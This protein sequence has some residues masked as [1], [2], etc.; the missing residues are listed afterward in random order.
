MKKQSRDV[1]TVGFALFAMF[2]GAGNIIFPPFIGTLGGTEWWKACLGF[3]LTGTGLPLLGVYAVAEAGGSS[4]DLFRP[5]SRHFGRVLITV[6]LIFIGPLFAIPRT[7]ATTYELSFYPLLNAAGM[8]DQ[9]TLLW[10][11][12]GSLLF[13]AICA[14][15]VYKPSDVVDRIGNILTPILILFLLI[16]IVMSLVAPIG[17]P[18]PRNFDHSLFRFGFSNGYQTMDALASVV[19]AG[20]IISTIRAKGYRGRRVTSMAKSAG[21]IAASGTAIVYLGFT[22]IGASGSDRLAPYIESGRTTLI[23]HAVYLLTGTFGNVLLGLI[24]LFACLTTAIGIITT[25]SDYFYDLFHRRIPYN[26]MVSI[27]LAISFG[28][29]II[30]VEGIINLAAPLL[31][32]VYPIVITLI[33]LNLIRSPNYF[34]G[35]V[36]AVTAYAAFTVVATLTGWTAALDRLNAWIPLADKGFGWII[37]AVIGLVVGGRIGRVDVMETRHRARLEAAAAGDTGD[38]AAESAAD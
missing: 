6:I 21:L 10:R 18:G 5:V 1:L 37:P 8:T 27:V 23:T 35:A 32:F 26:L 17:S 2:L 29:S 11:I 9:N 14:L 31:D 19:F 16:M 3:L 7:A 28:L 20:T 36:I 13:F 38:E 34:R 30:G 12:I 33:L 4:D 24:M 15:F 25:S 22:W